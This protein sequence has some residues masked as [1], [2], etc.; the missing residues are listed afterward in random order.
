[1]LFIHWVEYR[2][3]P[4]LPLSFLS[5]YLCMGTHVVI[6]ITPS[7]SLH[8]QVLFPLFSQLNLPQSTASIS[9]HK[10]NSSTAPI[11]INYQLLTK[12][13][14]LVFELCKK[15]TSFM[16]Q[17]IHNRALGL[18]RYLLEK[19]PCVNDIHSLTA[20]VSLA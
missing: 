11:S 3:D 6:T 8:T 4:S 7:V 9:L 15:S 2:S 18:V 12:L 13:L 5:F 17:M 19:V 14:S 16:H 20:I 1:M 10:P